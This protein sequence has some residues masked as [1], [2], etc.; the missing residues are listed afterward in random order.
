MSSISPQV[1]LL[2]NFPPTRK[3]VFCLNKN[4]SIVSELRSC[5]E[6]SKYYPMNVINFK[7]QIGVDWVSVLV[8]CKRYK[9]FEKM[10][11]KLF[12]HFAPK[13]PRV[14]ARYVWRNALYIEFLFS[15]QL[16]KN[17]FRNFPPTRKHILFLNKN[18]SQ[19]REYYMNVYFQRVPSTTVWTLQVKNTK[20]F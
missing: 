5:S 9:Y 13:Q 14:F 19:I 10:C 15:L 18:V 4:I 17:S 1:H 12:Q 6:N 7:L 16:E 20:I 3:H 8:F 2:R 11:V